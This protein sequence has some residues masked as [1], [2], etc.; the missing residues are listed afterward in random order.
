MT[1]IT[2]DVTKQKLFKAELE[3]Q[4]IERTRQL[5]DKNVDLDRM[6][7]ELQS[8]AYISSH[9]LQEPLRK[10]Q[11]FSK[12]ILEK[13]QENLSEKGKDYFGRIQ[14]AA[15]RMQI[16]INDLLSYSSTTTTNRIFELTDLAKLINEVTDDLREE[17]DAKKG[18]VVSDNM[19]HVNIIPFQ[20]RQL[21]QNLFTNALKFAKPNIPPFIKVISKIVFGK[22]MNNRRFSDETE[23]CHISIVDN[24][25][26]FDPIYKEKIFELFQRLHGASEFKGTGIG[27][28][29]VKKIVENHNGVIFA[30]SELNQG[31]TFNIYL[32]KQ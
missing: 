22:D 24:G 3:K 28:A 17:I 9:D 32:P 30:E 26:G 2:I 18:I 29:I 5:E 11:T 19:C 25:I 8:F 1:G 31:A 7:K 21:I 10:I 15:S 27:L 4:V 20:F 16:L 14:H 13:E 6:N 23:Y 12:R